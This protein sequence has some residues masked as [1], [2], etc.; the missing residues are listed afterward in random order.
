MEPSNESDDPEAIL[1]DSSFAEFL[2]LFVVVYLSLSRITCTL[3]RS[4]GTLQDDGSFDSS[5]RR[6]GGQHR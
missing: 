2:L 4:A 1:L 5:A 6:D 3:S